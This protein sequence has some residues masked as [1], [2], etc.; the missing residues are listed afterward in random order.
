MQRLTTKRS[1]RRLSLFVV[2]LL[3]IEFL[4]EFFFGAREAAWPLIRSDL[5]LS[6]A[7]IGMLLG[8]P[9][10]VSSIVE[11]FFGVFGDAGRRRIIVLGGGIF[12]SIALLLAGVS[13][14]FTLLLLSFMLFYPASGAFVSLSQATLMDIEPARQEYNMARWTFAGSVGVVA[15]PLALSAVV[16][17]GMGWRTLFVVFAGL[18]LVLVALAWRGRFDHGDALS[19]GDG[20]SHDGE[21]GGDDVKATFAGVWK[22]LRRGD[23][24][25]WLTL[26]S[27][28]D[29]MLDV[30][31][32]YLALYFVDVTGASSAQAAMAVAVWTGVGLLGDL[33]LIPLLKRVP[34][35]R[36]LRVSTVLELVLLPAFLLV[37]SFTGK[38]LLLGFLG[39][40]NAGWYAILKAQLY[41][42]MPGQSG[43]VLA[44]SNIF[45]FVGA[46]IPWG[47]G[48]VAERF[49]LRVTMWLLLL[50]PIALLIGLPRVLPEPSV[51][52]EIV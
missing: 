29:L 39:F 28:S 7:Q 31:L 47:L 16:A 36:Y 21:S 35:L 13:Q 48:L 41:A 17:L 10:I 1:T 23:V 25:R 38:L 34:G 33:L 44:V 22:A 6:Y 42:S 14:D 45:G 24:L 46:L 19:P 9:S 4:D 8:V 3:S 30:L 49:D 20:I 32:G 51:S 26:L 2:V 18:T 12:F 40:F 11:P 5:G 50:G 43:M 27:F 52:E 37:P 15:G